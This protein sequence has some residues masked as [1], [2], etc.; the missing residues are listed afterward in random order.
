MTTQELRY[1]MLQ[2]GSEDQWWLAV[3][4]V[5]F[6]KALCLADIENL[7]A[8]R[9]HQ[10]AQVLHTSESECG[11]PDWISVQTGGPLKPK[12]FKKVN[13]KLVAEEIAKWEKRAKREQFARCIVD[14]IAYRIAL[15]LVIV[16]GSICV[17]FL[18]HFF[19]EGDWGSNSSHYVPKNQIRSVSETGGGFNVA[20]VVG[21]S[22]KKNFVGGG[23][24]PNRKEYIIE[25]EDENGIIRKKT[26]KYDP[27]R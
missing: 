25:Y 24:V 14:R 11:A 2:A 27:T 8:T 20:P 15:T 26:M 4:G 18:F 19:D 10:V 1:K 9:Q 16:V 23:I 12:G 17:A 3:D 5:T 13:Q 21:R 22:G 7:L 6:E